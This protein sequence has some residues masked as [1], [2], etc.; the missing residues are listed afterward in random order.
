M[1]KLGIDSRMLVANKRTDDPTVSGLMREG[2]SL[3]RLCEW[4]EAR[5][6]A[7]LVAHPHFFHSP[8]SFEQFDAAQHPDLLAADIVSLYWI[9]GGFVS[10]ETLARFSKPLVWRLSD[11]WPFSGGCHYPGTCE[12]F[13]SQCGECPQLRQPGPGDA[14][15]RLWLR[16]KDAWRRLNLTI[17]APSNW[18]A[19]L[20]RRS[21]L[22]SQRRIVTIPT[23]IDL[24]TYYPMDQAEARAHLG[25]PADRKV[26]VFGA[27]SPADDVRKGFNEMRIALQAVASS[28]V[29]D[30]VLAVVFGNHGSMPPLPVPAISLGRLNTDASLVAAYSCADVVLAPSLEDNLPNVALESIACGVP[31]AAFDVCGMP[32]IVRDGW[33]GILAPRLEAATLGMAVAHLLADEARLKFMRLNARSHAEARFSITDQARNYFNLY[34]ELIDM[35]HVNEQPKSLSGASQ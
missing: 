17:V 30:K 3:A 26:I 25:I 15:H 24:K 19:S 31:V 13:E 28:N 18:M 20:A 34:S 2:L 16:K 6:G 22:F 32:D 12:R 33:N 8:A 10:P 7:R 5:N 29:S 9:N 23:G 21:T 35:R 11:V 1:L 27:M 4:L 14:S